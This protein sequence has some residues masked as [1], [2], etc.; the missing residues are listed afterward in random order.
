M[1]QAKYPSKTFSV[2]RSDYIDSLPASLVVRLKLGENGPTAT[3]TAATEQ[4]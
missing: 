1:D 2:I 3:V 4:V